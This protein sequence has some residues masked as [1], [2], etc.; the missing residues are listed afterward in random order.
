M[1]TQ[2]QVKE[3]AETRKV[4]RLQEAPVIDSIS[5]DFEHVGSRLPY[6]LYVDPKGFVQLQDFWQGHVYKV[7]GFQTDL[8]KQTIDVWW[9]SLIDP[10]SLEGLYLVT[11]SKDGNWGTHNTAVT[12]AE[13]VEAAV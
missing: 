9:D 13:W 5:D 12:S 1:R 4:L 3:M 10:A 2:R 8:A 11:S 6:P 7:I